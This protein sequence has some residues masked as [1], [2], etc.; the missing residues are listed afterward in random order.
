MWVDQTFKKRNTNSMALQ[1]N[2][3]IQM[4]ASPAWVAD[5]FDFGRLVLAEG[6]ETAETGKTRRICKKTKR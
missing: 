4:A 5:G 2:P 1:E 3:R 6:H